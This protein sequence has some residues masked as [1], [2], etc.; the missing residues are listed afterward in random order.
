LIRQTLLQINATGAKWK[1]FKVA[2]HLIAMFL[3]EALGLKAECIKVGE[4]AAALTSN[5]LSGL[6]QLRAITESLASSLPPTTE[7]TCNQPQLVV[8]I[9]PPTS[10]P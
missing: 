1:F 4:T 6:K 7:S 9:K 8:P 5:V 10:L 3:I 2:P